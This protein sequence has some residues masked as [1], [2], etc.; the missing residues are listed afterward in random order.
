MMSYLCENGAES[1]QGGDGYVAQG[2]QNGLNK[3]IDN[4]YPINP[5]KSSGA[6]GCL[7][8]AYWA[9]SGGP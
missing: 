4:A 6:L 1:I 2:V 5:Q 3:A 7:F 9:T 8:C